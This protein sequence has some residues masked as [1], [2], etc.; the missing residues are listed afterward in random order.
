MTRFFWRIF[1][2]AWAIV[3]I[4]TALT[5]WVA[6]LLPD[7]DSRVGGSRFTAQMVTLLAQQ[8]RRELAIDPA[9]AVDNLV[10][11]YVLDF[12]PVLEI[13]VLNP[14]GEDVLGRALPG[15]VARYVESRGK[16]SGGSIVREFSHLH[17]RGNGLDGYLVVGHEG[18]FPLGRKLMRP[19][20]RWLLLAFAL[21]ASA[22]V[23]LMLTRFIVL[24]IRRLQLAGQQV[25]AGDLSVRVAH[26]VGN[27]TDDIA[28]LAHDFDVMT[29]RVE[30]LLE[31]Q[32]R[33][34]R[35]VSHE[36]RSPL[37]RLRALL[38]IARQRAGDADAPQIDRME[39]EIERLDELIGEILTYSRLETQDHI[40]RHATDIVDLVQNVVYDAELEGQEA[41][42]Q[43]RLDAPASLLLKL[44]SG[45]IQRAVE[46]VIRNALKYTGEGTMIEVR[47]LS[48]SDSVRITVDDQGPGVPPNAIGQIFEP[49]YRVGDSRSTQSG[50]G[51]VG[52]AIAERS[53][54]LH[55]GS[56]TARNRDSGGL[57]I[58]I[59]LPALH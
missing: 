29:E 4:A 16:Q 57:R 50:S 22:V 52:L 14:G 31:S 42:K 48:E 37:A 38:S 33:L 20:I 2:S 43:I 40:T 35:D 58:E 13:Y 6:D 18:L 8:L 45:L 3:L 11:E 27:R 39:T 25:A 56:M 28:R 54:R 47:I 17:V 55:G 34:M 19:G 24:P 23:S 10:E 49:F 5:F 51:G 30:A 7:G 1:L 21:V 36:L 32:Q 53:I 15:S 12:T 46:N 44:D 9:T 41:D 26:T 59:V